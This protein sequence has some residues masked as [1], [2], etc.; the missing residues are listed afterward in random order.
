[1]PPNQSPGSFNNVWYSSINAFKL[2]TEGC[3]VNWLHHIGEFEMSKF[4]QSI[5][6]IV[7]EGDLMSVMNT[8]FTKNTTLLRDPIKKFLWILRI[9]TGLSS[10]ELNCN[11]LVTPLKTVEVLSRIANAIIVAIKGNRNAQDHVVII[12]NKQIIDFDS[13][14][15]YPLCVQNIHFFWKV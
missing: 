15:S 14:K 8:S 2:C 3:F 1:M 5:S 4:V 6:G 11:L 10:R 13:A 9:K 7:T 12:W